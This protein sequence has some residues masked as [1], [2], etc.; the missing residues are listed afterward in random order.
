MNKK[1][2]SYNQNSIQML[3][4]RNKKLLIIKCTLKKIKIKIYFNFLL[5][6]LESYE[7]QIFFQYN[8]PIPCACTFFLVYLWLELE[9]NNKKNL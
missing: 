4:S 7:E 5:Q 2:Y 8:R 3:F 1:F 6:S 9:F